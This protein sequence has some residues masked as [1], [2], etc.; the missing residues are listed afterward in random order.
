LTI[1]VGMQLIIPKGTVLKIATG[2]T[3]TMPVPDAGSYQIFDCQG[4]GQ[5]VFS[6]TKSYGFPEWWGAKADFDPT[7]G[8][9]TESSDSI[10]AL[11]NSGLKVAVLSSGNYLFDKTVNIPVYGNIKGVSG[12]RDTCIY[13]KN[14]GTW[15]ADSLMLYNTADGITWVSSYPTV[16][17]VLSN[18][19]IYGRY[20]S[21]DTDAVYGIIYAGGVSLENVYFRSMQSSIR[22]TSDYADHNCLKNVSI[23]MGLGGAT[24]YDAY[25]RQL[26][27]AFTIENFSIHSTNGLGLHVNGVY[28]GRIASSIL[29]CNVEIERCD[30]FTI[31]N[32]H[33]ESGTWLIKNSN[34]KIADSYIRKS[35]SGPTITYLSETASAARNINILDNVNFFVWNI[36]YP[37]FNTSDV[38]DIDYTFCG[39]VIR[40]CKRRIAV[41]GSIGKSTMYGISVSLGGSP[42]DVFN[43]FSY[44]HSLGSWLDLSGNI[45]NV[46]FSKA[47]SI[48]PGTWFSTGSTATSSISTWQ[49]SSG[50]YYYKVQ[51]LVDPVRLVGKTANHEASV[52]VTEGGNLA[53]VNYGAGDTHTS[54]G[55]TI[56]IYRGTATGSY[57]S[58]VDVPIMNTS[59]LYDNGLNVAGYVW[60]A[61]TPGAVDTV[62]VA[63]I[64]LMTQ[65]TCE[66]EGVQAA[67]TVGS[68]SVG[69]RAIRIPAVGS[70]KAW[71]CTVAGSPG[72][73]VS[74]GNL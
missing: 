22:K 6:G 58:Y 71:S 60:K 26:G 47:V 61:R 65:K 50:T 19:A 13:A 56:R 37:D 14:T 64:R 53:V 44:I 18:I 73:W 15:T 42:L 49:L 55:S 5:V 32:I 24:Y 38:V 43:N 48:I 63:D 59:W 40:D 30:S 8:V 68:W 2:K 29:N 3:L 17:T 27:D 54:R 11:F 36:D 39:L 41:I 67:P 62:C 72:T 51:I 16:T 33:T 46:G 70:P 35:T 1:P 66:V 23:T 74:E 20:N 12:G 25:F 45:M 28:G 7:S 21:V 69:D 9:G 34:T 10:N 4:T 31:S 57:D 52:A